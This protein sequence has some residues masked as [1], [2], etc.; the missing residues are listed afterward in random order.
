MLQILFIHVNIQVTASTNVRQVDD[1]CHTVRDAWF[2]TLLPTVFDVMKP[3]PKTGTGFL[4][5][6]EQCSNSMDQISVPE[7]IGTELHDT[8]A[9]NRYRFSSTGFLYWFLDSVSWVS[10]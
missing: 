6:A 8:P 5:E 4:H 7:K 10:G 2:Q 1:T 3:I 9:G